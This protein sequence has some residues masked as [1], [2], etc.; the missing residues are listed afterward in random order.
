MKHSRCLELR[1]LLSHPRA[2]KTLDFSET[3]I[4]QSL[5]RT[6][7]S[8]GSRTQSEASSLW[9]H[10]IN[11]IQFVAG[12]WSPLVQRLCSLQWRIGVNTKWGL[13][14]TARIIDEI[15]CRN[16][17]HPPYYWR[18]PSL[19]EQQ[20]LH[21]VRHFIRALFDARGSANLEDCPLN[22]ISLSSCLLIIHLY[23][24]HQQ[25]RLFLSVSLSVHSRKLIYLG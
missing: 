14:I 4:S 11:S 8:C 15:S 2:L 20:T 18:W 19:R 9:A 5:R 7:P 23:K 1:M 16:V 6:S 13:H 12:W 25:S 22:T 21:I 24:F 10:F 3:H 17:V